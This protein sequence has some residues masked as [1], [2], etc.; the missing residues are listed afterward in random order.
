MNV[1]RG[2]VFFVCRC[3]DYSCFMLGL[4]ATNGSGIWNIQRPYGTMVGSIHCLDI[5]YLI[6]NNASIGCWIPAKIHPIVAT[7]R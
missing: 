5:V 3:Y 4:E 6:K 7:K 1:T 2:G